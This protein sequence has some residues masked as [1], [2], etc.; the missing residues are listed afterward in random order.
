MLGSKSVAV[1]LTAGLQ[2]SQH[3]SGVGVFTV[4]L[5]FENCI[6]KQW[7]PAMRDYIS[8]VLVAVH[9]N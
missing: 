1:T 5:F 6:S 2:L 7:R 3:F 9:V 8:I 4:E